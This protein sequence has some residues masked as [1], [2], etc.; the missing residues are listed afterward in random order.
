MVI[1][2]LPLDSRPCTYDFP[3]QLARQSGAQVILPPAGHISEYRAQCD[4]SKNLRWLKEITPGC[5]ALVI[6]AEQLIHG[7]L[8]QSRG[9]RLSAD[10]QRAI[11]DEL[12]HIKKQTPRVRIYLS[13]VLMRTSISAVD[14][15]TR[16]WWEKVN[17]YSHV[18]YLALSGGNAEIL[19]QYRKLENEIPENIIESYLTARRV[20]HEIN[21][22]CIDLAKKG[23]VDALLILQEDCAPERIHWFEQRVLMEEIEKNGLGDRVFLFNGTDEAGCELIQKAIH[24]QGADAEIVWLSGNTDFIANYEDRPFADN[25]KGHMR[26]LNIREKPGAEKVVCI[27]PPKKKQGEASQVRSGASADYTDTELEAIANTIRTLAQ[28]G[29]HC[30]LLDVDFANGGNHR[31][32]EILSQTMPIENLWG[33]AGWNTASNSLGTLISQ[34]LSVSDKTNESRAFTAER[35][36]DDAIYQPI[37]RGE[38]SEALRS[39]GENIFGIEN[40]P[41]AQACLKEA[42]ENKKPLLERIFSGNIPNFEANLRWNRLFEAGI[43]VR[44]NGPVYT[45][46][47]SR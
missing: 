19:A 17:E 43:F 28:K 16:I 15:Q 33:Y 7:G 6:S 47:P 34:L 35:I 38:V 40:L 45:K 32:L 41:L 9:A 25:L 23:I 5:D 2:F 42:F 27:L 13:T 3:V 30:Y 4:V 44:G 31:L 24:P 12:K 29:R 1:G 46:N 14:E 10:E 26:A 22:A 39:M 8:I 11:L 36:L 20:N 37:V 21:L 18:R